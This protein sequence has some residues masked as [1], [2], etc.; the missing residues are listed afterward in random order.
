MK[1][2]VVFSDG[3]GQEGGKGANSNVYKLFNMV[4]NRT[5]KQV[6]FYDKG[7]GSGKLDKLFALTG[8]GFSKNIL[9][10]YRFIFENYEAGDKIYLFGFSR[11]AA[12]VRS[13]TGF[14]EMFG[15]LPKSRDDLIK[16]AFKIYK[17]A[18]EGERKDVAEKFIAKNHTMW[19]KVEFLG[20][21]DTVAALGVPIDFIDKIIDKLPWSRHKF[22]DFKLAPCVINTRH[23][24]S[25]DENRRTFKPVLFSDKEKKEAQTLKQYWFAGVHSDVGGGYKVQDLSDI[26]L[27]W[28][29]KEA[30]DQKLLIYKYNKV[31]INPDPHGKMHNFKKGVNKL[32]PKETRSWDDKEYGVIDI[33]ISAIARA[34][35]NVNYK[36]WALQIEGY[37]EVD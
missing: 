10:C 36:P 34:E 9:D 5:N 16:K 12:T 6:V 24:V 28:M 23:A 31:A 15:I 26:A 29:L 20:V 33:H 22:H 32:L 4:E 7:I 35:K 3:T 13:L 19:T 2:I 21:W 14:I 8:R 27:E 11:G 18:D 25:I 1:N 30:V 17:I 37:N